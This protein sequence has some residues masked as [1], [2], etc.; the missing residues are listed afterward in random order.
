MSKI[1]YK[2]FEDGDI[3]NLKDLCNALMRF[4]AEHARIKPEVMAG[5]NFDNRFAPDYASASRKYIAVA[6]NKDTPVGFAFASVSDLIEDDILKKP[7]WAEDIEGV[8]FYPEDYDVPTTIGTYKLLYVDSNYRGLS[9]GEDLSQMI[10]KW[11]NSHDDVR[12]LWVFVANGNEE[13]ARFYEKFGFNHNHS[14]F[15]G[16]IEAYKLGIRS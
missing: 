3:S 16:F 8:G 2:D 7:D 1:I 15:N 14:V 5:M 4:Q 12:D 9:I 11:L 6:Y 13:V 10:M